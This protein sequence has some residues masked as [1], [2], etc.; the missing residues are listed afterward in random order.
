MKAIIHF[1][2]KNDDLAQSELKEKLLDHIAQSVD[3]WL[4]G[5]GIIFIEFVETNENTE[6]H[7]D[8]SCN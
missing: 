6:K 5:D 4:K 7:S 3:L 1:E 8:I 2:I